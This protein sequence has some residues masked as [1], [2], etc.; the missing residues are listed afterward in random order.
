MDQTRRFVVPGQNRLLSSLSRDLQV[1]LLPRLEKVSLAVRQTVQEADAPVGYVWFPLS[2]IVSVVLSL[3]N[4]ATVEIATVGSEGLVGTAAVLGAERSPLSAFC[5]V[6]GQAT[7]MRADLFRRSL[8]EFPELS[9]VVHRYI[10][11]LLNQTAQSIAC[12][13]AHSVEQ[14]IARWLLMT[15]DRVGADEFQL[16]QEFLA[17][18]LGVRRPSVTVAACELQKQGLIRYQR[19]R[20]RIV[21][22]AGLEARA[23]ECYEKVRG[24]LDRLIGVNGM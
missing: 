16:T 8:Q 3:K 21:E 6:A 20:I 11:A 9:A 24:E 22:R 7:R 5:Q 10:Q 14:R 1:R 2:G 12:N 18:M 15:H 19:G 17:Q 23:C 4:G 13:H